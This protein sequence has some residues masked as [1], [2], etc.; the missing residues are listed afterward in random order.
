MDTT[1]VLGEA[2]TDLRFERAPVDGQIEQLSL[3]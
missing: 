3:F 1:G 2:L